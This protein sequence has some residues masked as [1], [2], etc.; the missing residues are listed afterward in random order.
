MLHRGQYLT[1][2]VHLLRLVI[3]LLFLLGHNAH[4]KRHIVSE[5]FPDVL[6]GVLGVLHH[7]VQECRHHGIGFK[8]QFLG[9]NTRHCDRMDDIRLTRLAF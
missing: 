6:D 9:D 8:F 7:I 4:K 3:L 5:T 2:V 1:V